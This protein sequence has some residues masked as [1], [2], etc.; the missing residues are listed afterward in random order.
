MSKHK[1][2]GGDIFD[3][4]TKIETV[5]ILTP[6][7]EIKSKRYKAGRLLSGDALSL[8]EFIV[9]TAVAKI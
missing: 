3:S 9:V 5:L 8:I 6:G 2:I 4:N 7:T 1:F